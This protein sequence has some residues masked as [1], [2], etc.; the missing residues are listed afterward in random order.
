MTQIDDCYYLGYVVKPK[1]L[2]GEFYVFLDVTNP[3]EYIEMESVFVEINKQLV[4]FFIEDLRPGHN[5]KVVIQFEGIETPDDAREL[6][7]KSLYLPLDILP[8][9]TGN[10]FYYH[11]IPGFQIIDEKHGKLGVLRKVQE[12][13]AQDLLVVDHEKGEILIP[14]LDDTVVKLNR[15]TKEL[16]VTTPEG[17]IE[18]YID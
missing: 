9:L 10:H 17:L 16:T 5:N 11:E 7:G 8:K 13:T 12:S 15:E 6:V 4:P 14:M 1:G 2:K 3:H 18:M